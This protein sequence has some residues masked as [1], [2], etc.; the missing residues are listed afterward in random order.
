[1]EEKYYDVECKCG[2]V[3][4]KKYIPIHF[5]VKATNQNEAIQKAIW[6]PRVRHHRTDDILSSRAIDFNEFIWIR[7]INQNDP[8]LRCKSAED[9]ANVEGL[10][11]RI[12]RDTTNRVKRGAKKTSATQ[13]ACYYQKRDKEMGK[14]EREYFHELCFLTEEDDSVV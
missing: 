4:K 7:Y 10:A 8:Y 11:D 5:A 13:K 1:M 2:H 9:V 14:Y 12:Q 6:I 3:G